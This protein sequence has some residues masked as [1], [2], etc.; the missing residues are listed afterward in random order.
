M[1]IVH[2][3]HHGL[4]YNA[5]T[6]MS[7]SKYLYVPNIKLWNVVMVDVFHEEF[8]YEGTERMNIKWCE[9]MKILCARDSQILSKNK[10]MKQYY[11]RSTNKTFFYVICFAQFSYCRA[12]ST[13]LLSFF[14]LD[15]LHIIIFWMVGC[16]A[17]ILCCRFQSCEKV[18]QFLYNIYYNNN[19]KASSEYTEHTNDLTLRSI[20][21]VF[22]VVLF[23]FIVQHHVPH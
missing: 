4:L 12:P 7:L 14:I 15:C 22:S 3:V 21:V 1:G 16:L 19:A 5:L 11:L 13:I 20:T 2:W 9:N 17:S 10:R 6:C 23:V 18:G 8:G